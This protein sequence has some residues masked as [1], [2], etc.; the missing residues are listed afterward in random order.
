M[1]K[2][3]IELLDEQDTEQVEQ[4]TRR[5]KRK[6]ITLFMIVIFSLLLVA[7]SGIETLFTRILFQIILFVGQLV[8]VKSLLDDMYS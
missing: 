6:N 5:T 2:N 3:K 7:T 4:D 1:T 8:I